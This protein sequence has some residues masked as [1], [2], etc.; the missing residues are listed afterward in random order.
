MAAPFVVDIALRVKDIIGLDAIESKLSSLSSAMA[1]PGGTTKT[2]TQIPN[3]TAIANSAKALTIMTQSSQQA[4][5]AI[6]TTSNNL[7]T[8]AR[9]S[10]SF[11]EAIVLAAKRQAAFV[12]ATL[13]VLALTAGLKTATESVIEFDDAM[14]K[15]DQILNEPR[16]KID[17][18]RQTMLDLSKQT[19][20]TL[21]DM[22]KITTTLAQAGLLSGK[23]G[24]GIEEF[25][26]PLS[27]VPLLP[28]FEN[29]DDA[30]EG[31]IAAL[32]QFSQE[33]LT[34]TD[35]LDKYVAVG[36]E[37]AV[38]SEDIANGLKRGG[39]AFAAL[40]GN[41]DEFI[42]L[43]TV[44]QETTRESAETI[45]TSIRTITTRM[46]RPV[47]TEFL[48]GIGVETRDAE[49]NLL[50]LL[51]I[52]SQTARVF[53]TSSTEQKA[54]IGE[55]L[56][57]YRQ[58]SRVF[59]ALSQQEQL[60]KVLATSISASGTA[61]QNAGK[62]LE[63]MGGQLRVLASEFNVLIQSLSQP[64]FVPIIRAVTELGKAF[65]S[66]IDFIK[67]VIP[68]FASVVG[69]AAG[70][71]VLSSS[72]SSIPKALA[73][74]SGSN[75]ANLTTA[76]P[77]LASVTGINA[78]EI[79]RQRIQNRLATGYSGG[80]AQGGTGVGVAAAAGA[81]GN[82]AK[83]Q[84]GQLAILTGLN[85]AAAKME[86]SF[87]KAG[88]SAGIMA[89]ET[90][91][92][93][94]I[95]VGAASLLSGKS[96][97]SLVSALGPLGATA[98]GAAV[99]LTAFAY[100]IGK[101]ADINVQ[102]IIDAAT[103]K[104]S[105]TKVDFSQDGLGG[106]QD[107][108]G[109]FG[110]I[111]VKT[112]QEASD[113]FDVDTGN[114]FDTLGGAF[115]Q[116]SRRFGKLLGGDFAG[117]FDKAAI[118]DAD[119]K[120]IMK[121]VV[122][123]TP[124]QLNKVFASAVSQFGTAGFEAGI[125]KLLQEKLIGMVPDPG[126]VAGRIRE[127]MLESVGGLK[128]LGKII[129]SSKLQEATEK[130]T[131]NTQKAAAEFA[132]I[133]V[134]SVLSAELSNLSTAVA[135]A[136]KAIGMNTQTFDTLSSLVGQDIGAPIPQAEWSREAVQKIFEQGRIGEFLDISNFPELQDLGTDLA[137]L[138]SALDSFF[139]SL[140]Q[141]KAA[142]DVVEDL[143]DPRV[144]PFDILDEYINQF[145]ASYPKEIP[146][147]AINQFKASAALLANSMRE[148][149]SEKGGIL[150]DPEIVKKAFLDVLGKQAPFSDAMIDVVKQWLD[151]QSQAMNAQMR[152]AE[153]FADIDVSTAS[154]AETIIDSAKNAFANAGLE[155]QDADLPIIHTNTGPYSALDDTILRMSRNVQFVN[156][157]LGE[158]NTALQTSAELTRKVD[159]QKAEGINV[160]AGLEKSAQAAYEKVIELQVGLL[161]LSKVLDLAPESLKR[162]QESRKTPADIAGREQERLQE[163]IATLQERITRG[164]QFAEA[165][166]ATD[167]SRIFDEP[168]KVFAN[169]L[170][171]S[172]SAV[173][174]FT[175]AL[176][177]E[178]IKQGAAGGITPGGQLYKSTE[179]MPA[180]FFDKGAPAAE[181]YQLQTAT[182]GARMDKVMDALLVA[183]VEQIDKDRSVSSLR[184]RGTNDWVGLGP[185]QRTARQ[186]LPDVNFIYDIP[187]LIQAAGLDVSKIAREAAASLQQQA[188]EPG[189]RQIDFIGALNQTNQQLITNLQA[190]IQRP[191]L[192]TDPSSLQGGIPENVQ[193]ILDLFNGKI[194]PRSQVTTPLEITEEET[195]PVQEL[196]QAANLTY[197]SATE[198]QLATSDIV[199]GGS[200]ILTAGGLFRDSVGQL[201]AAIDIQN[202]L[203][204][205]DQAVPGSLDIIPK[206][207]DNQVLADG[208]L[209]L[210]ERVDAVAAAIQTQT[211]QT[212][213][214]A[215]SEDSAQVEIPGL[216]EHTT[217]LAANN[218]AMEKTQESVSTLN[219]GLVQV[220]SAL[221]EG[222]GIDV[223][224]ISN[225]K[226]DVTGLSNV[227]QEFSSEFQ[228][229]AENV[230]KEQIRLVLRQLANN[231]GNAE[232]ANTFES[233]LG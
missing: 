191:D 35:V 186:Q 229:I 20:T 143:L 172:A 60:G 99:A 73:L 27:Q 179:R 76:I 84:I 54:A 37:F 28:T 190:L 129:Q 146:P 147:D 192:A 130:L 114:F 216:E 30:T 56:G 163:T 74:I 70:F 19:G 98:A 155:M 182:F 66:V 165:R 5:K 55:A 85:L 219:E 196:Q 160:D 106:L 215:S 26:K 212:I 119:V 101:T 10:S 118:T 67:P 49:G 92:A 193:S 161:Q 12:S 188:K 115:A 174:I 206:Q 94:T 86:E 222:I 113:Q 63:S 25:L 185:E 200:D 162:I 4:N 226:V 58:I 187:K 100:S 181:K 227:A 138:G 41:I 111:A 177:V 198:M 134:P 112:V 145:I 47:T 217:V 127:V 79:A 175:R 167:V 218:T 7:K 72:I 152:S 231:S 109:Q 178:D 148:Q 91:K 142:T 34:A 36:N 199:N 195:L 166:V 173:Q 64:L 136:A 125:D 68:L 80:V 82:F 97:T 40:G 38:T 77:G 150:P 203:R 75:I 117:A 180:S 29:I 57:G 87:Q 183:A 45:G 225:I 17:S 214:L 149:F 6:Q 132:R 14:V 31:I 123:S 164:R 62:E 3:A 197:N 23:S 116:L 224:T 128:A 169:A 120:D 210:G 228:A 95:I 121:K 168:A 103:Q 61:A 159:E 211:Q 32:K 105:E 1:S 83:S 221:N 107:A 18:L 22:T 176:T 230:A 69:Y 89:A 170:K 156:Q 65:I 208:L 171:E 96:V 21:Q 50:G 43:F 213:D 104:M 44:M 220:A 48:K 11:G 16:A 93:A 110:S 135:K 223:E 189:V 8:A 137:Q 201:A 157:I 33:G 53:E 52:L 232:L 59:A 2:N 184:S 202:Q 78:K 194:A 144:D 141:S 233:A 151:A 207:E 205:T 131:A 15:L 126:E 108:L 140:I 24:Q 133:R 209:S 204:P 90:L 122:G 9:A 81:A 124:E 42:A 39:G 158:Y 71:K 139:K 51:D 102:S 46:S 153:L 88:N 154:L 13:P